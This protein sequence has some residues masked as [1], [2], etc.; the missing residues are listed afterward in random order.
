MTDQELDALLCGASGA[1]L[2]LT[3]GVTVYFTRPHLKTPQGW[4]AAMRRALG[5]TGYEPPVYDV[6]DHDQI[7]RVMFQLADAIEREAEARA[8]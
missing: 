3:G 6:A 7:V 8:A 4:R 2:T 5:H 1:S